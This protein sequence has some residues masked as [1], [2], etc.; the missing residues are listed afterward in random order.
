MAHPDTGRRPR[1]ALL[2]VL[3]NLPAH[4]GGQRS[5]EHRGGGAAVGNSTA[6]AGQVLTRGR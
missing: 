2:E 3:D 5:E 6:A 1:A 4:E